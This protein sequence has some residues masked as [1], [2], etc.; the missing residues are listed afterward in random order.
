M[1]VKELSDITGIPYNTIAR[2]IKGDMGMSSATL[3]KVL[4]TFPTLNAEWLISGKGERIK[5]TKTSIAVSEE[6]SITSRI[7]KVLEIKKMSYSDFSVKSEIHYNSVT[8]MLSGDNAINSK[9]LSKV[10][11]I[12]PDVNPRWLITG[13]GEMFLSETKNSEVVNEPNEDYSLTEDKLLEAK[14]K[15]ILTNPVMIDIIKEALKKYDESKI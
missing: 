14:L 1:S 3:N 11:S 7:K 6:E 2:M 9:T 4:D 10:F 15:A 8:R 12:F 13:V 5:V